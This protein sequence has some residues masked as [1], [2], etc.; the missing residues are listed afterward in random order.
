VAWDLIGLKYGKRG[1]TSDGRATKV[2]ANSSAIARPSNA[3]R[4]G[5]A[6]PNNVSQ[7]AAPPSPAGA[8]RM[9]YPITHLERK[10][11][12]GQKHG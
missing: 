1:G 5:L 9:K 11:R 3:G 7:D 10:S 2:R 8:D 6:T 12:N 4:R